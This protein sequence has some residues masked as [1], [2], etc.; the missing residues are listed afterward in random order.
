MAVFTDRIGKRNSLA[1]GLAVG[2]VALLVLSRLSEQLLPAMAVLVVVS[3]AI[4]FG[5]ISAIPLTTE[6]RPRARARVLSLL[7]V[8]SGLGRIVGDLVAPRVFAG[9]GMPS[10]TVMAGIVALIA[11][12]VVLVGV[13]EVVAGSDDQDDP[14]AIVS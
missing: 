7:I 11:L 1:L 5:I 4:E 14:A 9:G 12:V 6:L 10:V 3:V 2:G 8:A 13:H